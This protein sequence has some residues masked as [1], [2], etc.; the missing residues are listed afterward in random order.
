MEGVGFIH[1]SNGSLEFW[2][3]EKDN[4]YNMHVI[5]KMS[6]AKISKYYDCGSDTI[7]RWLRYFDIYTGKERSNSFYDLN[8]DYFTSV[9]TETNAYIL[10]YILA[11]AHVGHNALM[12]ACVKSDENILHQIKKELEYSGDIK[13]KDNNALLNIT[14]KKICDDLINIGFN[15][16]KSYYVNIE[17]ILESIPKE[18]E[19]YFIRGMFDGDGSFRIYKYPY[20][21]KHTYHLGYTGTY[22]VVMYIYNMFNLHTKIVK[23][24]NVC[25]T[26]VTSCRS[27]I[28]TILDYLYKD[29]NIYID[30]KYRMYIKFKDINKDLQRL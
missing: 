18:L 21:K 12:F 2:E 4:M 17:K 6:S 3:K 25:Y 20:F 5:E 19:R 30:R 1:K 7:L 29:A 22:D 23:E 8:T 10:G 9:A 26:C 15:N 24:G 14:C 11:D 13:Y 27:D 28:N 16:R